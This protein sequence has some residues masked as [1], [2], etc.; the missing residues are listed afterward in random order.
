MNCS[1]QTVGLGF[2]LEIFLGML[3]DQVSENIQWSSQPQ[4]AGGCG[5]FIGGDPNGE[6]TEVTR[7]DRLTRV[8]NGRISNQCATFLEEQ[9][10]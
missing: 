9:E 5:V 3:T 7:C 10:S 6:M 2:S 8:H 1:T 4:L